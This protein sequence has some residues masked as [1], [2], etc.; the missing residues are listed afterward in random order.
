MRSLCLVLLLAAC[1]DDGGSTVIDAPVVAIDAAPDPARCLILGNYG[2]LGAK[3]GAV[4]VGG[5][6][7]LSVTLDPGPPR[8]T[9]Y[10]YLKTG[11]GVFAGGLANGTYPISGTEADYNNCGMCVSIIA[12][13]VTGS[14]PSKFYFADGGSVTLTNTNPPTGSLSNVTMHEVTSAGTA[15]NSGCTASITSMSFGT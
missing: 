5:P 10:I 12:D 3:T 14:G 13:I 11:K 7:S 8:D 15:V 6:T 9:F 1:G 4:G 2:A